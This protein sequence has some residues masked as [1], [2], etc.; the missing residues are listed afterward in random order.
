M[1]LRPHQKIFSNLLLYIFIAAIIIQTPDTDKIMK[2]WNLSISNP[3][4]IIPRGAIPPLKVP[5]MPVILPLRFS[6]VNLCMATNIGVFID[7]NIA[8][9]VKRSNI[10]YPI[11]IGFILKILKPIVGT[12]ISISN[13]P[14]VARDTAKLFT[15]LFFSF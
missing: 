10:L 12:A 11:N 3:A 14:K 15:F 4:R 7:I 1:G 5:S 9:R 6:G 2:G 8:P 13:A